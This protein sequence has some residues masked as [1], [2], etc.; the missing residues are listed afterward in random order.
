MS[1]E[2]MPLRRSVITLFLTLAHL[3]RA[4]AQSGRPSARL[5]SPLC[6][7][8]FLV[9]QYGKVG[10]SMI[11]CMIAQSLGAG[12]RAEFVR[13]VSHVAHAERAAPACRWG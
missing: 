11:E 10:S 4:A 5:G 6:R 3:R 2:S 13:D 1:F 9:F 8:R 12:Q 7:T